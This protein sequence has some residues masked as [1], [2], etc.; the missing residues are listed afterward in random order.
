MKKRTTRSQTILNSNKH[1]LKTSIH[2][3]P[4]DIA[5]RLGLEHQHVEGRYD[6][7]RGWQIVTLHQGRSLYLDCDEKNAVV[8]VI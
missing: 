6:P 7:C 4:A 2:D 8:R 1:N 3:C 5:S